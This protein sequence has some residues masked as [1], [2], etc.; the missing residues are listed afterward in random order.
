VYFLTD[1]ERKL[2]LRNYLP[3]AREQGVAEE[4]RGWNWFQPPLA[5]VYDVSLG[6][7]EVANRYCPSSRDVYYRRV[8]KAKSEANGAMRRGK[9]YHEVLAEQLVRAKMLIYKNGVGGW[10]TSV[11][12]LPVSVEEI[13]SRY[14]ADFSAEELPEVRSNVQTIIDFECARINARVQEVLI[15]QPY[16]G[17]DSLVS[18]AIPVVVEQ[19]LDG[20]FLGL[21]PNLSCDAYV[22]SEPMVVDLKFGEKQ[23]FHRLTTTGYALVMEAIN[24]FPVN[25]GCLIYV[26]MKENRLLVKKDIHIIDD[27]LRQWFIEERDE[28]MRMVY[29]EIDPGLPERCPELCSYRH[30]CY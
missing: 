15:K 12:I 25:L 8:I 23:N 1:E 11:E 20:T 30:Q 2:L 4:L 26:Q 13:L 14:R 3:K 21:S 9:L 17:V 16:I 28:K 24:E 18:L 19:K 6:V 10:G 29:E 7:Y 5:P 22:L 27:E